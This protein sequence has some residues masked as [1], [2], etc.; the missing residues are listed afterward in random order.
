MQYYIAILNASKKHETKDSTRNVSGCWAR[1]LNAWKDSMILLLILQFAKTLNKMQRNFI[2][3][4]S[5]FHCFQCIQFA[6]AS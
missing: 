5:E 6:W 2:L 3:L 1:T 4:F